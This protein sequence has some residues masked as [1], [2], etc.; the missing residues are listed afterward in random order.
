QPL[1]KLRTTQL[2]ISLRAAE[3]ELATRVAA[4]EEL[5]NGAR[6][7][8]LAQAAGELAAAAAV[9]SS[10]KSRYDRA[11]KLYAQKA[12]NDEQFQ[13]TAATYEQA[14]AQFAAAQAKHDLMKNGARPEQVAAAEA[15]K[16]FQVEQVKL[17]EEQIARHTVRAPFAGFISAEH[18]QVGQWLGRGDPIVEVIELAEVEVEV[19]VLEKYLSN[20]RTGKQVQVVVP[21]V[22]SSFFTG[23]ISNI[24][25]Q[26]DLRS[27][28]FPVRVRI[29]NVIE[30]AGPVLK[31]GML[32]RVQ[33]PLGAPGRSLLVDKDAVVLG[34][35]EPLI[36]V[37]DQ[38]V[39]V[40]GETKVS[41]VPV[42]LGVMDE[43]LIQV[44]GRLK[45]GDQVVIR[46]NERLADKE[47]VRV[48]KIRQTPNVATAEQKP[49]ETAKPTT[50]IGS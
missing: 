21:A 47:Q 33:M 34:G 48:V 36:Y 28:S 38:R 41:K 13:D 12:M 6:H 11:R 23:V 50:G 2:E 18:S 15:R 26:A 43:S 32:S 40:S 35:R 24:V 46:G 8:E 22:P 4:L 39:E 1:A 42:Q 31:A 45:A 30:E 7:E 20:L 9:R 25:P 10:T 5:K 19:F 16:E 44:T 37:L 29:R 49:T 17:I 27:R 14:R 3:A